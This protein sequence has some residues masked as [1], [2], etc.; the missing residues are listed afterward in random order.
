MQWLGSFAVFFY[1]GAQDNDRASIAPYHIGLGLS[2]IALVVATVES[3]ILEKLSFN[4]SCNV[5]GVLHGEDV[6][7]HMAADCVTGNVIGLLVAFSLVFVVVTIWHDK[8]SKSKKTR[9]DEMTPLLL[10]S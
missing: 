6:K 7:G 2:I 9:R 8:H 5:S 4:N 3:G 10:D 1:P